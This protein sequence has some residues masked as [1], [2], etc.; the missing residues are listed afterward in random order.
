MVPLEL[1]ALGSGSF[2]VV[3]A[4]YAEQAEVTNWPA[5]IALVAA[6]L[7]LIALALW[8]MRRGWVNR[9]RRQA[10]IP[11]PASEPPAG[12]RLGEPVEGLFAGTGTSGD[13]MDRI[14]VHDLGVR[15]RAAVSW[16]LA[17]VWFERQGARDLFIP[18]NAIRAVRADRGVA[19]TVR[20]RDS[21]VVLTWRLGDR[22]L[23]TGFR[24]D[25]TAE[26]AIVLDGF[27]STFA[28]GVQ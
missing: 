6:M 3:A 9:R 22:D 19:G 11:A 7:G 10:G 21:M 27:V 5:R 23:D 14:V 13:W 8:G 26:H 1:T 15:S 2:A 18:A 16:G 20:S 12:A 28:T 4:D 25:V 17:G 24:A